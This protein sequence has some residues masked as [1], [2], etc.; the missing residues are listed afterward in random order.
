MD[1][2]ASTGTAASTF[3]HLLAHHCAQR[4]ALRPNK[5]INTA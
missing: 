3:H 5:I 4:P 1:V 2:N